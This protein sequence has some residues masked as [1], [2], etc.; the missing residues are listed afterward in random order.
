[1]IKVQLVLTGEEG[2]ER[3]IS[4]LMGITEE[5]VVHSDPTGTIFFALTERVRVM[6]KG[7]NPKD[8]NA[9]FELLKRKDV[10]VFFINRKIF[11]NP[12]WGTEMV[13]RLTEEAVDQ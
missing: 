6:G 9:I 4:N 3:K 10:E 2:E 1:M 8:P 12:T 7:I 11:H 13:E 5:L